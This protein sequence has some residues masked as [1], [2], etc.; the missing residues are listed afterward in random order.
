MIDRILNAMLILLV[1]NVVWAPFVSYGVIE[2][3]GVNWVN[4]LIAIGVWF[5]LLD[6]ADY[7]RTPTPKSVVYGALLAPFWVLLR[8]LI[9]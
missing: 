6:I 8:S 7:Q 4:W 3:M 5:L 1:A 9:K 2:S